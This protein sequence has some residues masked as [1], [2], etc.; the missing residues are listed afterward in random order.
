MK[1]IKLTVEELLWQGKVYYAKDNPNHDAQGRFSSGSGGGSGSKKPTSSL[2]KERLD[3]GGF[4]SKSGERL[5]AMMS[6]FK[7][8]DVLDDRREYDAQ[9]L[10]KAY[11][12]LSKIEAT[13][14]YDQI[15]DTVTFT[16]MKVAIGEKGHDV[17]IKNYIT[18]MNDA[19]E[20][21]AYK[22]ITNKALVR[23]YKLFLK[24]SK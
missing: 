11:P 8:N 4:D 6:D 3:N 10:Q 1:N 13:A 22:G 9:D 16:R 2:E 21:L 20:P 12:E 23:D 7:K 17:R 24:V 18:E 15:Q 5:D 19:D 14:L